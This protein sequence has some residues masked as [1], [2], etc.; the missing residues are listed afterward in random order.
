MRESK[1]ILWD[2]S[3]S[4]PIKGGHPL[5]I[6][7]TPPGERATSLRIRILLYGLRP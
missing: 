3:S 2:H 4:P 6:P 1:H 5:L 7:T